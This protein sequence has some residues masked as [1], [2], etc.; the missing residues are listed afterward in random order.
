LSVAVVSNRP[1]AVLGEKL[2]ALEKSKPP[3]IAR[4]D[5]KRLILNIINQWVIAMP[6]INGVIQMMR[7]HSW[8]VSNGTPCRNYD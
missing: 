8:L 3:D 1:T 6:L 5:L 7:C 2:S 4:Q